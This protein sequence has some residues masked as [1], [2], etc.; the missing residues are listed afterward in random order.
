MK[1]FSTPLSIRKKSKLNPQKDTT[2]HPLVRRKFKR[3][4]ITRKL[5]INISYEDEKNYQQTTSEL[6]ATMYKEDYTP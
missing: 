1:I 5:Y 6:N 2:V 3:M 4:M